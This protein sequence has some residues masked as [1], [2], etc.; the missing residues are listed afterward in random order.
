MPIPLLSVLNCLLDVA[1]HIQLK[2]EVVVQTDFLPGELET[3]D[4]QSGL[5]ILR[6][7]L[8]KLP[9]LSQSLVLRNQVEVLEQFE[10]NVEILTNFLFD[11]VVRLNLTH[12]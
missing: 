3:L 12:H 10:E 8:Y 6:K 4:F 11:R 2:I 7:R 5:L 1:N 9:N